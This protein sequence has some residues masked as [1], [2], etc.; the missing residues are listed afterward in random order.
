MRPKR[1]PI[2]ALKIKGKERP[3]FADLRL[4][5][6]RSVDNP[7]EVIDERFVSAPME[8][9]IESHRWKR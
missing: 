8:E 9:V 7:H 3:F 6:Y 5:E 2:V 1:L 4:S